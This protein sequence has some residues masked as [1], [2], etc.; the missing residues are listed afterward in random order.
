MIEEP[1]RTPYSSETAPS[2]LLERLLKHLHSLPSSTLDLVFDRARSAALTR[3]NG[4]QTGAK[5]LGTQFFEF[6]A[7]FEARH[8]GRQSPRRGQV[9]RRGSL[10]PMTR[11][12]FDLGAAPGLDE[13]VT[14]G[15]E[16]PGA[17]V[18]PP[19]LFPRPSGPGSESLS[20][21]EDFALFPM[22]QPRVETERRDLEEEILIR[23]GEAPPDSGRWGPEIDGARAPLDQEDAEE[24]PIPTPGLRPRTGRASE[25][26]TR[27][28][29]NRGRLRGGSWEDKVSRAYKRPVRCPRRCFRILYRLSRCLASPSSLPARWTFCRCSTRKS[30]FGKS[31]SDSMNSKQLKPPNG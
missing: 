14:I 10:E 4:V 24:M 31:R 23:P 22:S 12:E 2:Q 8:P 17:N 19:S 7:P 18:S 9:R 30:L 15:P 6:D 27:K 16:R 11:I 3:W 25:R 1:L 21:E 5:F 13:P 29:A 28:A 20:E 26:P